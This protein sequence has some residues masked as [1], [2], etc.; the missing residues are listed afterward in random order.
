MNSG[1]L[2]AGFGGNVMSGTMLDHQTDSLSLTVVQALADELDTDPVELDPL[3]HFIDPEALDKLFQEGTPNSAEIQF[4]Y[5][6][7]T[8]TARADGSVVVDGTL[9]GRP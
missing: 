4:S 9:H 2:I 8:V 5:G 1:I 7:H 6:D 3:Y